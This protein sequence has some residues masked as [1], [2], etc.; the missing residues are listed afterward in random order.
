MPDKY[1]LRRGMIRRS[2]QIRSQLWGKHFGK[3]SRHLGH[4]VS[5]MRKS[6]RHP[7][8]TRPGNQHSP[9]ASGSPKINHRKTAVPIFCP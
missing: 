7:G 4:R 1:A 6:L 2:W 8:K 3:T 9:V 5:P